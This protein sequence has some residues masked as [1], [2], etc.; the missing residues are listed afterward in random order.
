MRAQELICP[1]TGGGVLPRVRLGLHSKLLQLYGI[2]PPTVANQTGTSLAMIE[3]ACF[4]FIPSA[5]KD[6]LEAAR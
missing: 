4:R 1:K 2:D 6:N 3:K 5:S